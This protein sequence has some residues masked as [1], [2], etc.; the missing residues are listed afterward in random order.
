MIEDVMREEPYYNKT[1]ATV[2]EMM[3]RADPTNDAS[4]VI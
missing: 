1:D 3:M 2:R 4:P